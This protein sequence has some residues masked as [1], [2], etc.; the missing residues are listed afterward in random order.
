MRHVGQPAGKLS[1]LGL[2]ACRVLGTIARVHRL[3]C[4]EHSEV[5]C[6]PRGESCPQATA[7]TML[8]AL[9]QTCF[10]TQPPIL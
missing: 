4:G 6:G 5:V 7:R 1:A 8:S 9:S 10:W 3:D 2:A